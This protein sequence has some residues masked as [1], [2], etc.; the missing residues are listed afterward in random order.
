MAEP[1]TR[2]SSHRN[3]PL[4]GE[5]ELARGPPGAPTEDSNTPTHFPAVS[6]A[7]TPAPPSINELFKRFMKAYLEFNQGPSQPPEERERPFKAKVPDVYYGKLHMDCYHFCQQC[8]DYFETFWATGTNRTPFAAS[9]LCGN[10][11]VR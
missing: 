1:R 6:R 5:D 7:P 4:G 10:I 2:R 8:E 3:P 9:F 11:S